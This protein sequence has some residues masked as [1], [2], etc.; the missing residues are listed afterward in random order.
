MKEGINSIEITFPVSIKLD[1]KDYHNLNEV[2]RIIC[3]RYE[4]SHPGRVMW[5]F[6]QGFKPTYIPMTKEEEDAGRH[7]EFDESIYAIECSEREDYDYKCT[8]CG[9]K[10][11]DHK[12]CII[13][14]A[15]GDCEFS[16]TQ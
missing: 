4:A 1:D 15:V 2:V 7:M 13:D 10:Q 9:I 11:G 16:A 12:H 3:A 6:G 5:A 8:K 14:P